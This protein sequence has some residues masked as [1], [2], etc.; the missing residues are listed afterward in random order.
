MPHTFRYAW[1][2]NGAPLDINAAQNIRFEASD[3]GSITINSAA[4]SDEGFYQ[5]KASNQWGT[6]L[7]NTSHLQRA[8]LDPGGTSPQVA[9]LTVDEGLPFHIPV[10]LPKSFPKPTFSWA[11]GR[12]ADESPK[13][14]SLDRRIQ[15]NENGKAYAR[16]WSF[17]SDPKMARTPH[18]SGLLVVIH[19]G[20]CF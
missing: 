2:R 14:V 12:I 7:T 20:P 13:P 19:Y 8:V 18:L 10:S 1:I 6:A 4:A 5:C 16:M 3:S 11:K 17:R 9:E 15:I